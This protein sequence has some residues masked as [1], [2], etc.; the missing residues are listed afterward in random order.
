MPITSQDYDRATVLMLQGEFNT[1]DMVHSLKQTVEKTI[2]DRHIADFVVDFA[3]CGYVDSQGLESLVWMKRRCDEH[4]GS[5]RLINLDDT[6][7]KVLQLT[8]LEP[9]FEI[10][11]DLASAMRNLR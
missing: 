3:A 11:H 10:C 5:V 1:D 4:F 2:E 9:Q 8:R 6:C 7:R